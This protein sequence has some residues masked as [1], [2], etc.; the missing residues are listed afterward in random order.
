MLVFIYSMSLLR[1]RRKN[2]NPNRLVWTHF[3]CKSIGSSAKISERERLWQ[4]ATLA[5]ST[6]SALSH[7]GLLSLQIN[8]V[9]LPP[10]SL[11][12]PPCLTLWWDL[13]C[14]CLH[15]KYFSPNLSKGLIMWKKRIV[16]NPLALG[17]EGSWW[18]A[19]Q[20]TLKIWLWSF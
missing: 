18:F 11:F 8:R 16:S 14:Y 6:L 20:G 3:S 4:H 5:H 9:A 12:N 2:K 13:P 19:V 1:Y 17:A 10:A 7:L 15:S